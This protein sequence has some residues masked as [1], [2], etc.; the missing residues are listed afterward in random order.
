MTVEHD[1]GPTEEHDDRA[2]WAVA[3]LPSLITDDAAAVSSDMLRERLFTL[4]QGRIGTPA[5]YPRRD[6]T[7]HHMLD[8]SGMPIL[9]D[10]SNKRSVF[11][12]LCERAAIVFSSEKMLSDEEVRKHPATPDLMR[13]L[14]AALIQ[15]RP[16]VDSGALPS[17][18]QFD[19]AL[20][21]AFMTTDLPHS[22]KIGGNRRDQ[23]VTAA[24]AA[25]RAARQLGESDGQRYRA[26]LAAAYAVFREGEGEQDSSD[27]RKARIELI[28]P[29]LSWDLGWPEEIPTLQSR[30]LKK[31]I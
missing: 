18:K 5:P 9:I 3:E 26:G 6:E 10:D 28:W 17:R 23:M 13:Y 7:G 30:G 1:A 22:Y 20:G 14:I 12:A 15:L 21:R 27:A 25:S 2:L 24:L 19:A 16:K 8:D 29:I 4:Q 31:D 11:L